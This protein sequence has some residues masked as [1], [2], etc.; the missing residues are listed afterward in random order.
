MYK[1]TSE[2]FNQAVE[3]YGGRTFLFKLEGET[4]LVDSGIKKIVYGGGSS[5]EDKLTIGSAVASYIEVTMEKT[6]HII[7]GQEISL[8]LGLKTAPGIEYVPMGIFKAKKP[9]VTDHE[10][11]FKAYDRMEG[12]EKNYAS[13]LNYP[14]DTVKVM[15][16]IAGL[17]GIEFVTEIEP[18]TLNR[19]D[20]NG[21]SENNTA[22]AG[23]TI[24]EAIGYIAGLYGKFAIFNREGKL[25][26]KWY[27]DSGFSIPLSRCFSFTKD[28]NDYVVTKIIGI[29]SEDNTC[30]AGNGTTGI[31]YSNPFLTQEIVDEIYQEKKEFA[32]RGAEIVFLGDC[33]LDV[34]DIVTGEDL[35]GAKYKIPV[36]ELT[37]EVDG[38]LTTTV[39]AITAGEEDTEDSF[40]GPNTKA[41]ERTH[42][43]LL[44]V[45]K[46]IATKAS[47]EYLEANYIKT[48]ELDAVSAEIENAVITN[49][50]GKYAS[51]EYLQT[52]YATIENLGAA[53]AK[54]DTLEVNALTSN[55][56]VIQSL[57]SGVADINTLMFGSAAGG[58]IQTEFSN[59]VIAN[60]GDAQIKS[61]MIK[62]LAAD[63]ITGLDL[64]TTKL[65]VH[66][67][68]GKSIWK[69]NTIQ[70]SDAARVRVQIGKDSAGDYNIYIWDKN[71]ALMFDPLY[72]I[73][74]SG[75][76]QAVIRNDM[77][78]DTANIS[79]AKLDISS[80]FKEI[81]GSSETIK[82]SKIY[83][84][85]D[86][87][88]LD[89]SFKNMSTTVSE[90]TTTASSALTTAQ[91][92][93]S[94]A[95]SALSAAS[96][97]A[98]TANTANS[99]ANT[100][101]TTAETANSTANKA[102]SNASSALSTANTASANAT[103][104]L[105]KVTTLTETVTTQGTQIT[106]IQGQ[107]SSKIWQ[108]DITTAVNNVQIGGRN[109]LTNSSYGNGFTCPVN[110]TA[111]NTDS[112]AVTPNGKIT[113]SYDAK[114]STPYV[115]NTLLV[116]Y[117]KNGVR[118]SYV[119]LS[120][121]VATTFGRFAHT[122]TIPSGVEYM[123]L[124]LRSSGGSANTYK[125]I[126]IEHGTK[127]TDWTPAPEDVDSAIETV[128]TTL[129]TKYSNLEQSLSGFETTVSATYATKTTVDNNL[130]TSKSYADTVGSN[131]LASAK[132]DTDNKLKSYAT[133]AAM[134]SAINQKADSI[135]STVSATYATKTQLNEKKDTLYATFSGGGNSAAYC[136]LCQI[137]INATYINT[138][139]IIEI[140]QR[141]YGYSQG[142][143]CFKSAA[144]ANPGL[145]YFR[146]TGGPKWYINKTATSTWDVYITK[147]ESWDSI[148]VTDFVN[149]YKETGGIAITW[150][151]VNANAVTGWEEATQLAALYGV[152][153][154]AGG[155]SGSAN[156]ATS[157]ALYST[158]Q[159][160][161]TKYTQ[162]SN[163]FNW[164]VQ[165]GTSA[166]DFT[167][168]DRLAS[169]TAQYINLN[170][171]VTF[172]GL[173]SNAQS[174]I[175]GA[176]NN[177]TDALSMA[178]TAN[179]T[180]TAAKTA[181]ANAQSAA[182]AA[183]GTANN[184]ATTASTANKRA[185]YHY[186]TCSTAAGTVAKTVTLSGFS[187]YTGATVSVL[188][189]YANT[190]ANPTLNVN[191]TGAKAIRVN[192]AAITAAYYWAANNTVTFV[193][194]GTY[195]V[196][197]DSSA[198]SII[199]A[200]CYN[201][202]KTYINGGKLYT[203]TVTTEK[204]AAKAVTAEKIS[205]ADLSALNA[206]IGGWNIS[207]DSI[208]MSNTGMSTNASKCAFW[209][210]E[211]NG[212]YGATGTNG[213]F[214]V[215][216]D[217][218][219]IASNADI[220]GKI[221]ATS[222]NVGDF[223]I[224][225]YLAADNTLSG[226]VY[227]L[228]LQKATS[229]TTWIVSAQK[230]TNENSLGIMAGIRADGKIY[231]T[232][233]MEVASRENSSN[234]ILHNDYDRKVYIRYDENF[235]LNFVPHTSSG[236]DISHRAFI[237][238]TDGSIYASAYK[239]SGFRLF[240]SGAYTVLENSSNGYTD[241]TTGYATRSVNKAR[242]GYMPMHASGFVNQSSKRYKNPLG[243]M[244]PEE[245]DKL[246]SL[247]VVKYDY[248]S[249]DKGQYGLYAEDTYTHIPTCVYKNEKG[250]ID[251][252][253][254]T[255]LIPFLIKKVQMQDEEINYLKNMV[256]HLIG[257]SMNPARVNNI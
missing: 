252:I 104:A 79:A 222:G 18:I 256:T 237:D 129:A 201:N 84:D 190:V 184:A 63:K 234:L 92:A 181:A 183:A 58:T 147:S 172:S 138:P 51:I 8:F 127:A 60:L 230:G 206:K 213:K 22:F 232:G 155:T 45:N 69:D 16:E 226:Y 135:T 53:N 65:S 228:W 188:F 133:T 34:W 9:S 94:T 208:Y 152:D 4:F 13:S 48:S 148:K 132:E 59:S 140:N 202:N 197:A 216:H 99:T 251:G 131:T 87:Q 96:A 2:E 35:S 11:T 177:A 196:M 30:E 211:T 221:T 145:N 170:G 223:C 90:V 54:I 215:G 235:Y 75:I 12:T 205:V 166:T 161:N 191:G 78:S 142:I 203:G 61:A 15:N 47:I 157:G 100:A 7:T 55:S 165:S 24:R 42:A 37:H 1:K 162:L 238:M 102:A 64:N 62:E 168:T 243:C 111:Y 143:I 77:V 76:K 198:N 224:S 151:C 139:I 71:G 29:Q 85:A 66:S 41:M 93:N 114:T 103:S 70:I 247:D 125:N 257:I 214:L 134:T 217:G 31:S 163:K 146:K 46:L 174:T 88:T 179:N 153:G 193:Y 176:A 144:D 36:M 49:L 27:E 14:T 253:D 187:L 101:K 219:V 98:G 189:S 175:T 44:L 119:W 158:N 204:L 128:N 23:Y 225:D 182:S 233:T 72:G 86:K 124:G 80:L 108:Q 137:K 141:G 250:E 229:S 38:G 150:K 241:I 248:I 209:A 110:S 178:N 107:I 26:F 121:T 50:Q 112:V 6:P 120:N 246:L 20:S 210:G 242:N 149:P 159:T 73:Q 255:K 113:I 43:Q 116:Q 186:G 240:S 167:I 123:N 40:K 207:A 81:N 218:H 52:N 118:V 97:A 212:K 171:L 28:E 231:A 249:G 109:L 227:R 117:Y 21:E 91:G 244:K 200:W 122:I 82:S 173:D 239:S 220:T 33:R 156:L 154:T 105:N 10:I 160:I 56:A 17:L 192:N 57:Q 89:I 199:A 74:E 164:I 236:L 130:A 83:V 25:E 19:P 245:A 67:E 194:N 136:H 254:Y 5:G 126:K 95:S 39:K 169:L 195:W 32:Y 68:D 115:G 185:T 180:A 106:T 3:Q